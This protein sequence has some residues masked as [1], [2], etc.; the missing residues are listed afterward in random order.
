MTVGLLQEPAGVEPPAKHNSNPRHRFLIY[1]K[2]KKKINF[3][4]S[5]IWVDGNV[6]WWNQVSDQSDG[7]E[8]G[9][10]NGEGDRRKLLKVQSCHV[11]MSIHEKK[12]RNFFII[13]WHKT[14]RKFVS[15]RGARA[16]KDKRPSVL[17]LRGASGYNYCSCKLFL[18]SQIADND[19]VT[20]VSNM[21][22]DFSAGHGSFIQNNL[23]PL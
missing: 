10:G 19:Y 14:I 1:R 20:H 18:L 21:N 6:V 8:K 17:G 23:K 11:T 13:F 5:L 9:E 2:Q 7:G 16:D 22:I 4:L 3:F 12:M 15:S